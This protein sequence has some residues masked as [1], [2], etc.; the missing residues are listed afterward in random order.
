MD[1][2]FSKYNILN[3]VMIEQFQRIKQAIETITPAV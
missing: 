3:R 1:I 2:E